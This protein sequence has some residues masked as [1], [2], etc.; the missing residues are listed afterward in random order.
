M[1][2]RAALQNTFGDM[3]VGAQHLPPW[4]ALRWNMGQ[5]EPASRPAVAGTAAVRKHNA[6]IVQPG[7]RRR[8]CFTNVFSFNIRC[9]SS[10]S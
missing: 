5:A 6:G 8:A 2:L 7:R 1:S 4:A 9:S 10:G 3:D